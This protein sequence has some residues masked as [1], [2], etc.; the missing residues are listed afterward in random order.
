MDYEY[1]DYAL[2]DAIVALN[3]VQGMEGPLGVCFADIGRSIA[4][5]EELK[6]QIKDNIRV[7][8]IENEPLRKQV[9]VD[10]EVLRKVKDFLDRIYPADVFT[11]ESGDEG[12]L[13]IVELRKAIDKVLG[14]KE[15]KE[16]GGI[17][18]A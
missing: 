1:L 8:Q 13:M 7:L 3:F 11:G 5:I 9:T 15:E 10:A 18:N 2:E 17:I 14:E 16:Q 6:K 4:T 12:A